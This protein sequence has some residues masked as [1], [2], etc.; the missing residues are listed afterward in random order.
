MDKPKTAAG[1]PEGQVELIKSTCLTIASFLGDMMNDLVIVGGLVPSLIIDQSDLP[2]GIEQH[3]GT[4]DLDI[5]MSLAILDE[6]HYQEITE[7]FRRADFEPDTNEKG[8]ITPQRWR[9]KDLK[10]IKVDF[11]I[12]PTTDADKGG[13]IKHL[14]DDFAALIAPGLETAFKDALP[15]T[16]N[17]I[18]LNGEKLE[19]EIQVCGPGAYVLLKA[20]AFRFRGENKDAYDLYYVI[21]NFGKDVNEVVDRFVALPDSEWKALAI[22]I[23]KNDFSESNSIGPRRAAAF[24]RGEDVRDEELEV[25]ISGFVLSFVDSVKE[26]V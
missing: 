23:L 2:D 17:G 5:G 21:R 9:R 12:P 4:L 1:Y 26:K 11:L 14:E 6:E 22:E 16:I 15:I 24:L 10:N 19:R 8:N 7:R 3:A 25:E 20:L 18:T 13:K